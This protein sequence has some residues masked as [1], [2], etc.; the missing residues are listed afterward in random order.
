M[1]LL[2]YRNRQRLVLKKN[3]FLKH[4]RCVVASDRSNRWIGSRILKLKG[5]LSSATIRPTDPTTAQRG[6]SKARDERTL[7]VAFRFL[8]FYPQGFIH[9]A[10][11]PVI[12]FHEIPPSPPSYGVVPD[13][14]CDKWAL[15]TVVTVRA[16]LLLR[17]FEAK[18]KLTW[19]GK[20][21][22]RRICA[23]VCVRVCLCVDVSVSR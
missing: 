9:R 6:M 2:R 10:A 17:A 4:Q 11:L 23:Y 18:G 16:W 20:E 7:W 22:T 5:R 3:G 15:R 8:E 14:D 12:S 1:E 13:N 19:G 21:T